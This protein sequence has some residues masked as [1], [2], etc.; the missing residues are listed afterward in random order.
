[1]PGYPPYLT[2]PEHFRRNLI[3]VSLEE[4]TITLMMASKTLNL[5]GLGCAFAVIDEMNLRRRFKEALAG[6]VPKVN[7]LGYTAARVAFEGCDD[8]Q[9]ALLEYLRGNRGI[10]QAAVPGMPYISNAFTLSAN[11]IEQTLQNINLIH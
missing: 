7:A 8:W 9:A 4:K 3:K 6:I 2:A 5:P 10:V 11:S 1:V